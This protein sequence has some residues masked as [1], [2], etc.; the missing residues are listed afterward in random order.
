MPY[1]SKRA[2]VRPIGQPQVANLHSMSF[3]KRAV[4]GDMMTDPKFK[5][6]AIDWHMR[7]NRISGELVLAHIDGCTPEQL[8]DMARKVKQLG[9]DMTPP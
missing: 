4:I 1:A 7:L 9:D 8:L 6:R 3:G 2:A 5:A